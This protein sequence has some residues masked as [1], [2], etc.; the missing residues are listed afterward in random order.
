MLDDSSVNRAAPPGSM[1]YFSLLYAAPT[2]RDALVALYLIEAEI[3]ESAHSA[4]HD[5]AHTRLQWWR[6]EVDRLVNGNPQHPAMRILGQRSESRAGFAKLHELLSAADMDLARL[7]YADQHE[8]QAY[9]SR[10]SGAA[11]E[12]IASQLLAPAPLDEPSRAL[13]NRLGIGIRQSEILRDLR[14]DAYAGRVYLP[15]DLL[16]QHGIRHQDLYA[17]EMTDPVRTALQSFH[18]RIRANLQWPARTRT[19]GRDPATQDAEDAP[20]E[21]RPAA[22]RPLRILAALHERL[23]VRIA[24]SRYDVASRRIDLGPIEKPWVAWRAARRA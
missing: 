9:C 21:T 11:L 22:L 23:L 17:S 24:A 3:R 13:A 19:A 18:E 8:L 16:D 5:V 2:Q 10:S 7:T 6:A 14:Q 12:L 1:R 15:L 4:N 20:D